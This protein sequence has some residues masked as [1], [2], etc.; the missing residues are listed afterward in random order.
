MTVTVGVNITV[1]VTVTGGG[2]Y[3]AKESACV[4]VS[5]YVSVCCTVQYVQM[6]TGEHTVC[7]NVKN[8]IYICAI[9][10]EF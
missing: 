2:K 7:I 9:V 4:C 1:M 8:H 3:Y 6:C 5:M 10:I